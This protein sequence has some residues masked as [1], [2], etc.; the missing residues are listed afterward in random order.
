MTNL[1]QTEINSIR[2]VLFILKQ[3][4]KLMQCK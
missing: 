2:I 3:E 1:G 4:K